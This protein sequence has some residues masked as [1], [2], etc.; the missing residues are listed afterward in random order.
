M[1]AM[2]SGLSLSQW[3]TTVPD[4]K[5][6]ARLRTMTGTLMGRS[7][8]P[9]A[10]EFTTAVRRGVPDEPF[11]P[12][13]M[14]QALDLRL[15]LGKGLAEWVAQ[16]GSQ[17]VFVGIPYSPQLGGSHP[18]GRGT[19]TRDN[20][21]LLNIVLTLLAADGFKAMP[22]QETA[23]TRRTPKRAE[24]HH[25][26]LQAEALIADI[27]LSLGRNRLDGEALMTACR[28]LMSEGEVP[29][30]PVGTAL[31]ACSALE[32]VRESN[33]QRV[34]RAFGDQTPT[35]AL[36]AR[37]EAE[38][39]VLR[40]VITGL[41][42]TSVAMVEYALP[43]GVHGPRADLPAAANKAK[44]RFAARV[45][46]WRPMAE[47]IVNDYPG[48]HALVQAADWYDRRKDDPV[49]KLAG[50]YALASIADANVQY[51]LPPVANWKG[52]KNYLH[53]VQ[54]AVY[55]LLFG[56][57]GLVSEVQSLLKGAF[58]KEDTRPKVI[59][60]ISVVSPRRACAQALRVAASA[61]L[62]ASTPSPDAPPPALGGLTAACA[63]PI[64]GS[65]FLPRSRA[66]SAPL[67]IAS[68]LTSLA[69][70]TRRN[71]RSRPSSTAR[72]RCRYLPPA[73][74]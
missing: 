20:A 27:A 38:R 73:T 3:V 34:R 33:S 30:I 46:A 12:E 48:A 37:T 69:L 65:R 26:A 55:D 57:S 8:S 10:I 19:T 72:R 52:L 31:E 22:F 68:G 44:E 11:S 43:G 71:T 5:K 16:Q 47:A 49:N 7:K 56:H 6:L 14:L 9:V 25:K 35:I 54:A 28:R 60:G 58:H 63:G 2:R 1:W 4:A 29:E 39:A 40:A 74:H 67:S 21:D 41:F 18:V 61:W 36:V 42:G 23:E 53:R 45:A 51:L 24:D 17:G 62:R 70:W 15:D 66:V 50:R 13:F 64:T 59:I 32:T